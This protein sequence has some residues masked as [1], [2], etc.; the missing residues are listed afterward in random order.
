MIENG[1]DWIRWRQTVLDEL[2]RLAT[3]QEALRT[4]C[5]EEFTKVRREIV[6]ASRAA[7]PDGAQISSLRK[8]VAGLKAELVSVKLKLWGGSAFFASLVAI[9]TALVFKLVFD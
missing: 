3:A 1:G 2:K 7:G 6:E 8:E 9:I 5:I 4:W